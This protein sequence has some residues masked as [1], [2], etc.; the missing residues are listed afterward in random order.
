MAV[1]GLGRC[2]ILL[3]DTTAVWFLQQVS[4]H[5]LDEGVHTDGLQLTGVA[6]ERVAT[7]LIGQ[8][9]RAA[10]VDAAHR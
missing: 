7:S 5:V 10:I 6:H 9:S 8:P 1:V 3:T 4:A 2:E